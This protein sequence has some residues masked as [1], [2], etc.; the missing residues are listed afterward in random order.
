MSDDLK[1]AQRILI[2]CPNWVGDIV[3]ATPLF[4]CFRKSFPRAEMIAVVRSYARGILEGSPWFDHVIGCR[5][6][7]TANFFETVR[8]IRALRPDAAVLLPNSLRSYFSARLGGVRSIYGYKWQMRRFLVTDGPTPM[9][10][11]GVFKPRPMVEYYAELGRFLGLAMPE[12]PKPKLYLSDEVEEKGR[13]RLEGYGVAA[14]EMVI[15]L[16]PGASF[17]SSKCWP[18]DHFARLAELIEEVFDCRILLFGGPG[19]EPIAEAI[20]SASR[21]KIVNTV[22]DRIDLAELK[23]L[24]RRC[25]LL[26]TNDTGPRHYAVAFDVP[27]VVLM[28]PTNPLYTAANLEKTRVI[29]NELECAPCHKKVCPTDHRCMEGIPPERVFD[30]VVSLLKENR[31]S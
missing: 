21:A 26:V 24:I 12:H 8:R 22:P 2:R 23:P 7:G 17:G 9:M 3:M 25:D 19:E 27:V 10:E 15:G 29:R 28:G 11:N 4:E 20:V 1:N 18:A 6:K 13:R 30:E 31:L 14:D 16:N 5:D